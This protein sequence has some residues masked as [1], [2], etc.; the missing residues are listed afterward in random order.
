MH[1]FQG[2][3]DYMCWLRGQGGVR[4]RDFDDLRGRLADHV[5][6]GLGCLLLGLFGLRV[7]GLLRMH[8]GLFLRF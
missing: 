3:I 1:A 5:Y 8:L 2:Q 6:L 4:R 7:R